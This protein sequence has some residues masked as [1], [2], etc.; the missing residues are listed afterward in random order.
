M[1]AAEPTR[2]RLGWPTKAL[3]GLNALGTATRASLLG[4]VLFFYNRVLELDAQMVSLA[5][6]IALLIDAFWDPLVGQ[7]SDRT[8]TRLGRRHPYIYAAVLPAS[9][10]FALIFM[11]PLAWTGQA[12]FLYLLATLVGARLLESLIEIPSSAL[13]PELSRD[14]D[15]RTTLGSWRYVFLVVFGRSLAAVLAYGV[16]LKGT[17]AQPFGQ[18]NLAG[19]A[20]YAMTVA[21][22]SLAVTVISALATQRFVPF[23][24]R[25]ERRSPSFG[26][27][28][29][30]FAA[31]AG[32]RNFV[33]LALSSLIFGIAVG[34][35]G[36]LMLYFLTDFW[37][38][39]SQAL[40]QLGLWS[41]S[42][43][44]GGRDR[45]ALLGPGA[46]QEAR[47]SVRILRRDSIDH[48]PDRTAP[49][50]RHAAQLVPLGLADPDHRRNVHRAAEHD[51][52]RDRHGD[53][54]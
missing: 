26:D 39:P 45:R 51:G 25:P 12:L 35:T 31:A 53:V 4:A 2:P 11:P 6:F 29:R 15:E 32:D 49:A 17:K 28:A 14:Y 44:H 50:R 36:G 37:Q 42:R 21:A 43:R 38:L 7:L 23:M 1:S 20:P 13:L 10:C 41:I 40:L 54:G 34:I 27:M 22:I 9:V 47:L 18:M 5:I 46:G 8:Q 52:L 33:A 3:Y 16:F 48:R 19:Y 30:E 24:H